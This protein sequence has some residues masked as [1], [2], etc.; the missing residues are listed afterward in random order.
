MAT[1]RTSARSSRFRHF[2]VAAAVAVT[3]SGCAGAQDSAVTSAASQLLAAA[4]AGDGAA[5]CELLAPAAR[6][7][8]EDTTGKPCERAILDEDLEPGSEAVEVE[9]FDT[10]AQVVLGQET[11]FLSRFDGRWL[12]VAAGCTPVPGHPY[13]C[14]IGMP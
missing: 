14:S 4:G 8:L 7:E 3:V 6:T 13:D 10:M 11:M 9:V 1:P 2:V 12:V 5:A